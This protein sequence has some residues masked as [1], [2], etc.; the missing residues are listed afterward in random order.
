MSH[1]EEYEELKGKKSSFEDIVVFFRED[2][3][4]DHLQR[5]TRV[6]IFRLDF[7]GL[8][9]SSKVKVLEKMISV[10]FFKDNV[11]NLRSQKKGKEKKILEFLM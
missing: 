4:S 6:A 11:W 8:T 2:L 5:T 9:S 7:Q 10:I 3:V 1:I